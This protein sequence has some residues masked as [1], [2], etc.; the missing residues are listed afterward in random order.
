MEIVDRVE[1]HVFC[2]P[3][4]GGLPHSK[5]EVSGVDARYL[6]AIVIHQSVQDGVKMIDVP[7]SNLRVSKTA[8]Q[9][10]TVQRGVEGDVLPVFSL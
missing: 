10:S 9:V 4:K 2:V 6:H 1:V 5:V 7:L 3:S 8:C